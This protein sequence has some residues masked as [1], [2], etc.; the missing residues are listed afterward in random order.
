M[1]VLL[2]ENLPHELRHHL[3]GQQSYTVSYL[4]WSGTKNG[5]LL[6]RAAAD[7]FDVLITLDSGVAYQQNAATLPLSILIISSPSSDIDDLLPLVPKII[8]ALKTL[9]PRTLVRVG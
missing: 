7:G 9:Q 1:K 4:G 2:D 8:D 3:P 6:R 5:A